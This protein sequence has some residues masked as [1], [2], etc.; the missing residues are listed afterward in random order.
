MVGL[1]AAA[2][3]ATCA[4]LLRRERPLPFEPD[5]QLLRELRG[6]PLRALGNSFE[7]YWLLLAALARGRRVTG[8]VRALP[9]PAVEDDAR[10]RARRAVADYVTCLTPLTLSFGVD[11][12]HRQLLIHRL[13]G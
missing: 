12:E 13:E 5:R 9:F 4:A 3:G 10:S 1:G 7:V 8:R 6:V 11:R 2:A